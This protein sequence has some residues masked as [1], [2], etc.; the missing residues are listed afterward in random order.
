MAE[1]LQLPDALRAWRPQEA[2]SGGNTAPTS[3]RGPV[4]E[5][6]TRRDVTCHQEHGLW[7]CTVPDSTEDPCSEDP[8]AGP[9]PLSVDGYTR[10]LPILFL[11][12]TFLSCPCTGPGHLSVLPSLQPAA[13]LGPQQPARPSS[14]LILSCLYPGVRNLTC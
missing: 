8:Q 3:S 4:L 13:H 2:P 5:I 10:Q 7:A 9:T 12:F 1:P 6:Q 14:P 11:R